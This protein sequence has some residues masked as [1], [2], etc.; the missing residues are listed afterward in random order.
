MPLKID[1]LLIFLLQFTTIQVV[2]H[3]PKEWDALPF[4]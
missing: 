4:F 2:A 1:N 3:K